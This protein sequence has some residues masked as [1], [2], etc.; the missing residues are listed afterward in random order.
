MI[1][2]AA[3]KESIPFSE[4]LR[5][6]SARQVQCFVCFPHDT[7]HLQTSLMHLIRFG[8][9]LRTV[10]SV[11]FVEQVFLER[12]LFFGRRERF[13]VVL[14]QRTRNCSQARNQVPQQGWNHTPKPQG[15]TF[16]FRMTHVFLLCQILSIS[17]NSS[18]CTVGRTCFYSHVAEND[19][20]LFTLEMIL[21]PS[22]SRMR[23]AFTV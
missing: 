11:C 20:M 5:T 14:K 13:I 23:M 17:T 12:L 8:E 4:H 3:K 1:I 9:G 22:L 7:K 15:A 19:R 21:F 16:P 6:G 10:C 2:S 18:F